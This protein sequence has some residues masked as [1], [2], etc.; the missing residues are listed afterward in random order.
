[1]PSSAATEGLRCHQHHPGM[2]DDDTS[3]RR[4]PRGDHPSVELGV[5]A[6]VTPRRA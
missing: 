4:R 5:A 1:M 3:R 2:S 6:V